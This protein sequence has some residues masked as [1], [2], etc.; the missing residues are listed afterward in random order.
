MQP[1]IKIIPNPPKQTLIYW[2]GALYVKSYN[3]DESGTK[4]QKFSKSA[5]KRIFKK[6]MISHY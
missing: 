2:P 3:M 6:S 1:D 4:H 5:F